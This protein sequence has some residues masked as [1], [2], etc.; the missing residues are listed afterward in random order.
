MQS[1]YMNHIVYQ[2]TAIPSCSLFDI[3][4]INSRAQYKGIEPSKLL[5]STVFKTAS[6]HSGIRQKIN[7]LQV[8]VFV[9]NSFPFYNK[10][11][12]ILKRYLTLSFKAIYGIRT[13]ANGVEDHYTNHYT[14]GA[15]QDTIHLL[16]QELVY[17]R[18]CLE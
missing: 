1:F 6:D 18:L 5:H 8:F 2:T 13:H 15:K 11:I 10:Q 7:K 9:L 16:N 17:S 14:N 4:M 3:W 12:F